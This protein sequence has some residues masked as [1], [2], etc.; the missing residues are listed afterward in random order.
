[1]SPDT[2]IYFVVSLSFYFHI[3]SLAPDKVF[4]APKSIHNGITIHTQPVHTS[5][6]GIGLCKSVK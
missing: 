4:Q 5:A 1:M 6:D 3:L 2:A